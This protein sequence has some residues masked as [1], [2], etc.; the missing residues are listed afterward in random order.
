MA[1][2]EENNVDCYAEDTMRELVTIQ[3]DRVSHCTDKAVLVE[4]AGEEMWLPRSQIDQDLS[5]VAW[6]EMKDGTG[7]PIE[8]DIPDWLARDKGLF[9]A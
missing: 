6:E 3:V 8:I 9:D 5:L 2:A 1:W 4:V 7:L